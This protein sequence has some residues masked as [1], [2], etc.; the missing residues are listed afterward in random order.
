MFFPPS[1]PSPVGRPLRAVAVLCYNLLIV[2]LD[3]WTV[4]MVNQMSAVL[5]AMGIF[6]GR[7]CWAPFFYCQSVCLPVCMPACL[8]VCL[9]VCLAVCLAVCLFVCL[10]ARLFVCL[11]VLSIDWN[12]FRNDCKLFSWFGWYIFCRSLFW[13]SVPT[14]CFTLLTSRGLGAFYTESYNW[15][16][17]NSMEV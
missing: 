17:V 12:I 9:S 16:V 3:V 15:V 2:Q 4:A 5:I 7:R 1:S 6:Q 11:F 13:R 8:P 14:K 10:F